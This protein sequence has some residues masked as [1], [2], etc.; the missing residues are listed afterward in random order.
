[1]SQFTQI[2]R[3]N[4]KVRSHVLLSFPAVSSEEIS[5][6]LA[7]GIDKQSYSKEW[8]GVKVKLLIDYGTPNLIEQ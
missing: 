5:L 3:Q 6:K 2:V 1:M 8:E 7:P 4:E